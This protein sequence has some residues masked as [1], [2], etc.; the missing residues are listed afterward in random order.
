MK[1]LQ[2]DPPDRLSKRQRLDE[3]PSNLWQTSSRLLLLPP[4]LRNEIYHYVAVEAQVTLHCGSVLPHAFARVC[5]QTRTEFLPMFSR[6]APRNFATLHATVLS[7]DNDSTDNNDFIELQRF[8]MRYFPFNRN[9]APLL[10]FTFKLSGKIS[11]ERNSGPHSWREFCQRAFQKKCRRTYNVHVN[12]D[13]D[14]KEMVSR[15]IEKYWNEECGAFKAD[16]EDLLRD[17][18]GGVYA[19]VE[20]LERLRKLR[21]LEDRQ[22]LGYS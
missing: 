22:R 1:R 19:T 13:G 7:M 20:E 3:P 5:R 12:L 15:H 8:M 14:S 9:H 4:E 16:S 21:A 2:E 18:E 17:L 6:I 11:L 10:V